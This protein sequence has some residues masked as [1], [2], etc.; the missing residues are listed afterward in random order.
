MKEGTLISRLPQGALRGSRLAVILACALGLVPA[1]AAAR[2]FQQQVPPVS[3]AGRDD[4]ALGAPPAR[5]ASPFL[6]PDH[7]TQAAAR[8]LE[9]LGLAPPG[10]GG[11]VRPHTVREVGLLFESAIQIAELRAPEVAHL[12]RAYWARF[13]EEF[14]QVAEAVVVGGIPAGL[15]SFGLVVTAGYESSRGEV[16]AGVGYDSRD[17]WTG[18]IPVAERRGTVTGAHLA[19]AFA[20]YLSFSFTPMSRNDSW[21]LEEFH[22]TAVL[23]PAGL[24]VGRRSLGYHPGAGGGIVP[25]AEQPFDGAGF[26]LDDP[27][28]LP[29]LLQHLGPLRLEVFGSRIENGDRIT[30][31]WF[32]AMHASLQPHP[33]VE[34][35]VSRGNIFGGKGNTPTTFRSVAQMLF[36]FHAGDDGEFNNEVFAAS[37]RFRPPLGTVPLAVYLEW[38]MDDSAG[39]WT[40]GPARVMGVELAA[41]P[42]LPQVALGVERTTFRGACC[43]NT[44]WYRNWSLRGGWADAGT[45]LGH[46]L[47]GEGEEWLV[48][49]RAD[50]FEARLQADLTL[51]SRER[52]EE[53]L[54]APE[55][56]GR[57]RGARLGLEVRSGSAL[58]VFFQ[59]LVEDG[60]AG[61]RESAV[62]VGGRLIF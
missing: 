34:L 31:P 62:R 41:V 61:W 39:A 6:P 51:F 22:A 9:G 37:F 56:A 2:A 3:G 35:G 57:S 26:F 36:G 17:D 50:L 24:W 47:A 33:R 49:S 46:P 29:W 43:G 23:G 32:T 60:D 42:G 28:R 58:G 7:W 25:S 55:R 1:S 59:G 52:G 11:G 20:P 10:F 13:G 4:A 8:R 38:W 30:S 14:G 54:L 40:R 53:N 44:I 16:L 45:P 5:F 12:A 21:E 19:L 15:H 48:Q 18:A 27:V